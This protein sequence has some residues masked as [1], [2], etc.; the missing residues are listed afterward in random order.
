MIRDRKVLYGDITVLDV[1]PTSQSAPAVSP[2][3]V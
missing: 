1:S 2:P 3:A